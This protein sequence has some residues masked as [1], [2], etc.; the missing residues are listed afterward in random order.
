MNLLFSG[1]EQLLGK[2]RD[3]IAN[4]GFVRFGVGNHTLGNHSK[5]LTRNKIFGSLGAE[6]RATA[7]EAKAGNKLLE[8]EAAGR[9]ASAL[10]NVLVKLEIKGRWSTSRVTLTRPRKL[11]VEIAK[12]K[13]FFHLQIRSD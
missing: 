7:W 6:L 12:H 1:W 13:H 2:P 5:Q 8:N 10:V 4:N 3:A 11:R 9:A